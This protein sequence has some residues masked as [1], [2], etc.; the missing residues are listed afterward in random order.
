[1]KTRHSTEGINY[2]SIS[3]HPHSHFHTLTSLF[4]PPPSHLIAP[5]TLPPLILSDAEPRRRQR[6]TQP[7]LMQLNSDPILLP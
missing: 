2:S 7:D 4:I 3:S 5:D 6:G 1:M